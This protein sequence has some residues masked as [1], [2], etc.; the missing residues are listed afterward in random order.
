MGSTAPVITPRLSLRPVTA[1]DVEAVWAL[2][3]DSLVAYWTG[4]W[5][6]ESTER[7][8]ADMVT[9]WANDGVGKWVARSRSD[10][11][12]VGRGGLTRFDLDGESTLE[13]GWAVRDHLTGQ[14]FATE[15]GRA[16]MQWAARHLPD[17]PV[18]AFTEVHNH[19]SQAV[20]RRIGLHETGRIRRE[21]LIEGQEGLHPSAPFALYRG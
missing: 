5:T 1:A 21:G 6:R 8:A 4:P 15:I 18:I 11:K 10:D 3:T 14:G 17:L 12:L 19:A 2:H 9:R 20:M 13:A 16:A 7:W